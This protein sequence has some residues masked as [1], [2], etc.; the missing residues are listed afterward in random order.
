MSGL[1]LQEKDIDE[2]TGI[3]GRKPEKIELQSKWLK[4]HRVKHWVNAARRI[5]VPRAVIE[6]NAPSAPE[7]WQPT[8]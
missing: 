2:F 6:Q 1:F 8:V 4:E 7:P 5:I 3:K